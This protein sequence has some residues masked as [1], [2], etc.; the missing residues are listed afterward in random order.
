MEGIMEI[1]DNHP[2]EEQI[3]SRAHQIYLERG[4]QPGH[5]TD[6]W[7][8]AKYELMQLPIRTL[9]ELESPERQKGSKRSLVSLVQ[10][11]MLLSVDA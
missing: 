4:G 5:E 3:R 10:G 1:N 9:A 6:N 8:E 7:L 2:T 11:A